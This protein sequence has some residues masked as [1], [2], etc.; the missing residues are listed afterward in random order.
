[1]EQLQ[2]EMQLKADRIQDLE[3][4]LR[5]FDKTDDTHDHE[6]LNLSVQ[7]ALSDLS[8]LKKSYDRLVGAQKDSVKKELIEERDK[9]SKNNALLTEKWKKLVA[10]CKQLQNQEASNLL[11]I[12]NE[13]LKE[14]PQER[15]PEVE[16]TTGAIQRHD[17]A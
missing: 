16:Q 14:E 5:E 10:K 12:V 7:T 4:E 3:N 17:V 15:D 6:Q 13:S 2:Q 1:M 8:Q 9:M 11:L